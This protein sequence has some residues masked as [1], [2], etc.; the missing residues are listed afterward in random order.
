MERVS[1][2]TLFTLR[3]V[4]VKV[5]VS[6]LFLLLYVIVVATASFPFVVK[7]SAIDPIQLTGSPLTWA[8]IFCASLI[9]S[10][11][12][13]EFSHVMVAQAKG[14]R[15]RYITLMMLGGFSQME[16]LP[17]EPA[18][19]FKVAIVGPIVSLVIA[20]L[21]FWLRSVT[22]STN[23]AFFGFWVGQSNLVLGLFNLLPAFPTDGGRVLRAL[24]VT[25]LGRLR[26]T[27]IAVQVSH[28]FAWMFGI[29]G[30]LQ[31]N[32]LLIL[33]AFF[34]YAAS[35]SELFML[36]GQI[37]LKGMKAKDLMIPTSGI[38]ATST[39]SQAVNE[40]ETSKSLLL[41]VKDMDGN[42]SIIGHENIKT[43]PRN[44][45]SQT[46]VRDV[47]VQIP[48]TIDIEDSLDEV[49]EIALTSSIGG[50]PVTQDHQLVGI[51]KT[52]DLIEAF[53]LKRMTAERYSPAPSPWTLKTHHTNVS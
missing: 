37:I 5:H 44:L 48:K 25:R 46:L 24:L 31:F 8:L 19:E 45:W 49:W 28:V 2:W 20:S 11:F 30:F 32:I 18:S 6:L 35:K 43:V 36:W 1:G 3:G 17:E 41:P 47:T 10:I 9:V 23:L 33:I 39:L 51:I 14:F 27:Q 53:E 52:A 26:G 7:T 29:I 50:V 13:H 40:M 16:K 42:R 38:S 34:V 12:L 21:L 4:A 15:V 22:T